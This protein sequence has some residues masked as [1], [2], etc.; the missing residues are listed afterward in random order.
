[1]AHPTA[2]FFGC[3][4]TSV[5]EPSVI[6][7]YAPWQRQSAS[8]SGVCFCWSDV[9]DASLDYCEKQQPQSP[10][11][12]IYFWMA[13]ERWHNAAAIKLSYMNSSPP[14]PS[15]RSHKAEKARISGDSPFPEVTRNHATTPHWHDVK[16][17]QRSV[18][19]GRELQILSWPRRLEQLE[20]RRLA[21]NLTGSWF[22]GF[23]L[24][25]WPPLPH[26]SRCPPVAWQLR[27]D[28]PRRSVLTY[29]LIT[30]MSTDDWPREN[31]WRHQSGHGRYSFLGCFIISGMTWSHI[32]A[33]E[34]S[35]SGL[36][37]SLF[38]PLHN[39]PK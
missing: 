32:Q 29:D 4:N 22:V 19:K 11:H 3:G 16:P 17:V 20:Q 23:F 8:R 31:N 33:A 37:P 7:N 5:C 39:H 36:L 1:M 2:F 27:S 14:P 26:L 21:T 25:R 13:F 28:L 35:S 30:L 9:Q 15:S 24:L 18:N 38:L 34:G 12:H 10:E 6:C